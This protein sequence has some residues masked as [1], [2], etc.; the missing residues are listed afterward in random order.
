MVRGPGLCQSLLE[1]VWS[2]QHAE[3]SL[4]CCRRHELWDVAQ[5]QGW[6]ACSL[7]LP[8]RCSQLPVTCGMLHISLFTWLFSLI[9]HDSRQGNCHIDNDDVLKL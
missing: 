2:V 3:C 1:K 6:K 7:F 5:G 9:F 8:C 4:P